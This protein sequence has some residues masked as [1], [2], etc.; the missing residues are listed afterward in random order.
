M[1]K[2]GLDAILI[3]NPTNIRYFSGFAGTAGIIVATATERKLFV[4]FR[5]LEQATQMAPDFEPVQS[6]GQ[7]LSAAVDFLHQMEFLKI[8]FENEEMTVAEFSRLTER[9]SA[10][11]WQPIQLDEFRVVKS[12]T[13]MEKIAF[14]AGIADSALDKLLSFIRPGV[15]EQALAATLEYEMRKLGSEQPS[16]ETILASGPRAA[17]PHGTASKRVVETGD[18]VVIDFGAVWEGYHS[19]ITRTFC[20]GKAS[21]R[22]RQ[23][24]ETVLTA[25]L[26]GLSAIR[27][28]VLCREVDRVARDIIAA[29]GFGLNFGHGLGHGVGLEIHESPRLS[30]TADETRLEPGM[31]VTV[32]PGIYLP[33]W[34]GVRIEDLVVVTEAGC[35]ILSQTRKELLELC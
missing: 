25:N 24:Y 3:S 14:S 21:R 27:P 22:Q 20:V 10:E 35:R 16:F 8:G 28:G 26:A 34:G 18:F 6:S 7:P 17:L 19:D 30:K 29:A 13:E 15:T 1:K 11:H 32:E 4:D 31:V 33:G 23:I 2:Q 5:Y 12:A 9:I